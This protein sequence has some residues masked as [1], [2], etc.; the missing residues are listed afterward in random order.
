MPWFFTAVLIAISAATLAFTG[1]LL[2]AVL[3]AEPITPPADEA[4][5]GAPS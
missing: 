3:T 4:A 2:R 5:D 1:Y